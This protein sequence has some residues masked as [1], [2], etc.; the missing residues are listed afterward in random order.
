MNH[1]LNKKYVLIFIKIFWIV[2]S[3][4]LCFEWSKSTGSKLDENERYLGYLL[5]ITFPL[6]IIM[7]LLF[8]F[9]MNYTIMLLFGGFIFN[10]TSNLF[11]WFILSVIIILAG[12]YQWFVIVPK[13]INKIKK[14]DTLKEIEKNEQIKEDV[15]KYKKEKEE[16][17]KNLIIRGFNN[18]QIKEK[19]SNFTDD[20]INKI[21]DILFN[22]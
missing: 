5:L 22:Q 15:E 21:R 1:I 12:Y 7:L 17:I 8:A 9:I 10:N 2:L 11:A 3:L 16:Y 18:N 14:K 4:Y 6:G 19:V 13:I 20:D